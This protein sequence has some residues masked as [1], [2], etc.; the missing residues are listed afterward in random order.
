VDDPA[1]SAANALRTVASNWGSQNSSKVVLLVE[2]G[3]KLRQL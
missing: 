1:A 3:M 2:S